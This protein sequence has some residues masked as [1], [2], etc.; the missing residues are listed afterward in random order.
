MSYMTAKHFEG[1][2]LRAMMCGRPLIVRAAVI[3]ALQVMTAV[4]DLTAYTNDGG[5]Y[6]LNPD[7]VIISTDRAQWRME[8]EP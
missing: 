8:G 4:M 5:H 6:N 2:P 3:I 7:T 1:T